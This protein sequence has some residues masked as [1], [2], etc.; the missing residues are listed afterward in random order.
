MTT[1]R[2]ADGAVIPSKIRFYN[3]VIIVAPS[4]G[5]YT[6]PVDA[7]NSITGASATN[8][9]LVKIMPG[10][11][12]IGANSVQMKPYVDIEGSGELTTKIT[13]TVSSTIPPPTAGVVNGSDDAEI[14]FLTVEN[15]GTGDCT[16][17]IYKKGKV[18]F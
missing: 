17:A 18:P 16:A 5:D 13:G 14:R 3:N 4:G 9:Y 6:S 15:T 8:T 10:V 12:D 2:I 1:S 7:M 11:Y